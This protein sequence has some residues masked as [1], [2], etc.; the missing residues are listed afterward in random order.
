MGSSADDSD[1]TVYYDYDAEVAK[2]KGKS[3]LRIRVDGEETLL[4]F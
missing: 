3:E 1:D 2:K 4:I